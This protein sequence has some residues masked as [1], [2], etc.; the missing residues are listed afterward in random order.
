MKKIYLLLSVLVFTLS[1]SKDSDETCWTCIVHY[2]TGDRTETPC[3]EGNDSPDF[4]DQNNNPV[5]ADCVR[6]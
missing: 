3:T 5:A 6:R 1:C 2:P 4:L